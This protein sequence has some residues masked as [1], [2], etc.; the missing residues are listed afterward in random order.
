MR[1]IK[2]VGVLS[3]A[4]TSALVHALSAL[5]FAVP[6]VLWFLLETELGTAIRLNN[7]WV[8]WKSL[9]AVELAICIPLC[10]AIMGF[11]GGIIGALLYN[12]V[13]L[14]TGGVQVDLHPDETKPLP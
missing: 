2:R 8:I 14:A 4:S 7:P 12:L 1:S 13:A 11:L 6:L 9:T 10:V 3:V 5:I